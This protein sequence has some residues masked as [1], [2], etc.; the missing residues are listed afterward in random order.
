MAATSP[1]GNP[2]G[3]PPKEPPEEDL[4]GLDTLA[5]K[6]RLTEG[7]ELDMSPAHLEQYYKTIP[8]TYG[9]EFQFLMPVL[10]GNDQEDPHN[11][12]GR[13]D[14][15]YVRRFTGNDDTSPEAISNQIVEDVMLT[16]R[17]YAL[18]PTWRYVGPPY[19]KRAVIEKM[20]EEAQSLTRNE[21]YSQWVVEATPS[22]LLREDPFDSK[23]TWVG[24]KV[25]SNKRNSTIGGHFDPI[26]RVIYA[27]R[28]VFRIRV[29]S[30]T[31]L[32]VHIGELARDSDTYENCPVWFRVFCTMWWF[33]E[34]HMFLLSHYSRRTNGKCLPLREYSKLKRMSDEELASALEKGH[35]GADFAWLYQRMHYIMPARIFTREMRE[36]EFIWRAKDAKT[37]VQMLLV[38][39]MAL[40][41]MHGEGNFAM[42]HTEGRGSLGFQGFCEGADPTSARK[43][44]DGE[45]GTI[46]FRSMDGS[47][48]PE[49]V[50]NW[51]TLL[52]RLYDI[53]RRGKTT[54]II[55]II[56]RTQHG[57]GALPLLRDLGLTEHAAY[58]EAHVPQAEKVETLENLFLPPLD[59][60]G[61]MPEVNT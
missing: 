45:T 8:I 36:I 60:N 6:P 4:L 40:L 43:N 47:L 46:E 41:D 10:I 51:V 39:K 5:G 16:L 26:V 55:G 28:N 31:S 56:A 19:P 13:V 34:T 14:N 25:R 30:T 21:A 15:R 17:V 20:D 27:L 22:L 3:A 49:L 35:Q 29:P 12:D 44:N 53:C 52:I 32:S 2:T 11:T 23:Y 24:V 42:D 1:S 48:D 57:Y 59:D 38:N 61:M 9:V 54:D 7:Q 33:I 18:V 58:F 50:Y 37:L